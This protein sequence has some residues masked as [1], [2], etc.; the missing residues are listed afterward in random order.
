MT[1]W[2]DRLR[3]AVRARAAAA[4]AALAGPGP[5]R[6]VAY[7]I[8][9]SAIAATVAWEVAS[10]LPHGNSPWLAPLT[11][12]LVVGTTVYDSFS[13]G[14]QRV[15]ATVLGVLVAYEVGRYLGLHWWSILLVVAGARGIGRWHR[16]GDQGMQ[17]AVSAILILTLASTRPGYAG[18]RVFETLL[19]AAIGLL[20]NVLIAPPVHLGTARDALNTLADELA[21]ILSGTA[22]A[23]RAGWPP[24]GTEEALERARGLD[25]RVEA[26]R[27]AVDR[28]AE[29]ARLNPRAM[30]AEVAPEL[31]TGVTDPVLA[32][33]LRSLEHVAVQVRGIA[34]AMREVEMGR[35]DAA[36][37][38][39]PAFVTGYADLLSLAS[40]AV[41]YYGERL[42]GSGDD[43]AL[44]TLLTSGIQAGAALRR[45]VEAA[46]ADADGDQRAA[47]QPWPLYG[48]LLVDVDRLLRELR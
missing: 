36:L 45:R 11:A 14:V 48:A 17:I 5:Q 8:A 46:M 40:R 1:R 39:D 10:R 32:P 35:V 47:G 25:T 22:R 44:A 41:A 3:A 4:R 9:K 12:M 7:Q 31:S 15:A 24:E 33:V 28:S 42:P 2:N 13:K 43:D 38:A 19:G 27:D 37:D 20:T 16:F 29:S 30:L 6:D 23:L 26:A 34:R 18:A 21:E